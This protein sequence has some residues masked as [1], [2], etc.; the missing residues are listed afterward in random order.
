M[1][2]SPWVLANAVL[3]KG[4]LLD[5]GRGLHSSTSRLNLSAF[6]AIGGACRGCVARVKGVFRVFRVFCCVRHGSS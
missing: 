1:G 3:R 2:V 5:C 4:R 6:H